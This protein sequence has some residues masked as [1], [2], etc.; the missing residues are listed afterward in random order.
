MTGKAIPMMLV[1]DEKIRQQQ[2][3]G[4]LT[5]ASLRECKVSTVNT[6]TLIGLCPKLREIDLRSNL[7]SSWSTLAS[8]GK[9]IPTLRVLNIS[10]NN[11]E[12]LLPSQAEEYHN[13]FPEL[14]TLIISQTTVSWSSLTLLYKL[15]PK[16]E[17]LH[18]CHNN[19]TQLVTVPAYRSSSGNNNNSN[20]SSSSASTDDITTIHYDPIHSFL[21]SEFFPNLKV[22]NLSDNPIKEWGQVYSLS[23]LPCLQWLLIN[24]CQLTEVW[25]DDDK[26]TNDGTYTTNSV[27]PFSKLEQLSVTG[28]KFT[29]LAT[30]DAF[31]S[32]INL[33][34]L[35]L[36]HTDLVMNTTTLPDTKNSDENNITTTAPTV[37]LGPSE[38]RQVIVARVP[39]LTMLNGSEVRARER[40]D[41]EKTY[42]KKIATSFAETE[43]GKNTNII[44]IF[45]T[46]V[47]PEAAE[48]AH[49]AYLGSISSS[50]FAALS[51]SN[52]TTASVSN[53]GSSSTSSSSSSSSSTKTTLV[54]GTPTGFSKGSDTGVI[55]SHRD[56]SNQTVFTHSPCSLWKVSSRTHSPYP[57]IPSLDA[58]SLGS[59]V[60]ESAG[61][62]QTLFP[63]YF[64]LAARYDIHA[65]LNASTSAA[66]SLASTV[67]N[68]TLRSMAGNSCMMEPQTKKL[69]LSMT[70]GSL[71]QLASRLFKCD[72]AL[73][74][75]SFRDSPSSYPSLMD[76]DTKPLSY[77]AVSEG[78]EILIEEIDPIEAARQQQEIEKQKQLRIDEQE[79]QG[80]VLRKAQ[81]MSVTAGRRAVVV[82]AKG[83]E[84]RI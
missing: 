37:A 50:S 27:V 26:N 1:G 41:A 79:K 65:P 15:C 80:E 16:L 68:L 11:L 69:P 25:L 53:I 31:D 84:D 12:T 2:A 62:L 10:E 75:L 47:V 73:Q 71:K 83:E 45:G 74:R 32:F 20:T 7:I 34:N 23:Y 64:L 77:Y 63:R 61:K 48:L 46:K 44:D 67:A 40:E 55:R 35:R 76:D 57:Y 78:G 66:S 3:L 6:D 72:I 39:R 30:I 81:E 8:L 60:P 4:K 5:T 18:A 13:C 58:W 51:V 14:R 56:G 29:S 59:T 28:N 9:S 24:D 54:M 70:I 17:E 22:L 19:I 36:I 43:K 42:T 38:A 33:V 52:V 82:A 49:A 21:N